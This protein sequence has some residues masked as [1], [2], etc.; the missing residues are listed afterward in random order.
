MSLDNYFYPLERSIWGK[1]N[2]VHRNNL[3]Q[4]PNMHLRRIAPITE[5]SPKKQLKKYCQELLERKFFNLHHINPSKLR[6]YRKEFSATPTR[7]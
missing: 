5:S 3:L 6:S 2:A 1:T 7:R 4:M